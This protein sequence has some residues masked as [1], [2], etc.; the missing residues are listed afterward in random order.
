M[1]DEFGNKQREFEKLRKSFED[2]M[3]QFTQ[4]Q[5]TIKQRNSEIDG[6]RSAITDK[7]IYIDKQAQEFSQLEH[8]IA[9]LEDK[10]KRLTDMLNS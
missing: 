2:L 8:V 3:L 4:A 9:D 1:S 6:A 10:N 5:N 7:Q